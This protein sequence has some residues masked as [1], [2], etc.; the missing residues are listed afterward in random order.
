V[1]FC[2]SFSSSHFRPLLSPSTTVS[3]DERLGVSWQRSDTNSRSTKGQSSS[4]DSFVGQSLPPLFCLFITPCA[5]SRFLSRRKVKKILAAALEERMKDNRLWG[6]LTIQRLARGYIAR[7]SIVRSVTLC[8][9]FSF[10]L[11]FLSR[12]LSLSLSLSISSLAP[13]SSDQEKSARI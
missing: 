4:K 13:S 8:L 3:S 7:H 6:A 9:T 11:I 10:C 12:S 5:L 2:P 1:P